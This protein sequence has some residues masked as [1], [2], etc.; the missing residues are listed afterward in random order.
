MA[1]QYTSIL[2]LA[3]PTQGELDG[4]WGGVVNDNITS[5]VEEAIAGLSTI[6]TWTTNSHTLTTANGVTSESRAAMLVLTDS[7]TA[8][9][10]AGEVIC[11]TAT[12]IYIVKNDTGQTITVKTSAG[13]G[14]DIPTG[15]IRIV[16][17]DGTNVVQASA[18]LSGLGVTATATELNVLDG[19]TATTAELNILDGVTADATE[20]NVLDGITATT[21]ELNILDG[22][23]STAAE[24]NILDG[25]TLTTTELNYVDGVTSAIQTQ[26]DAKVGSLTDLGVTATSAELNILDGATL[27]TTELNYVDGVT[28]AI[29]TQINAVNNLLDG[30]TSVNGID[31]NSGSIVGTGTEIAFKSFAGAPTS[32][33][34][35]TAELGLDLT[36]NAL[37]SSTDGTDVVEIGFN[38]QF[39]DGSVSAP[40]ITFSS[41]TD[42]G[43]YRIGTGNFA[44]SSNGVKIGE[45][46]AL[47]LV[48]GDKIRISSNTDSFQWG[49]SVGGTVA[50]FAVNFI[51]VGSIVTTASSTSYNTSSDYRLK[52]NV[53]P[54]EN[55]VAR[56]DSLNPVRFNFTSDPTR[57]V[58][59]FLAH[60]VTP[61]VP[62]AITGEKDA[63]DADGNPVYQGIDQAK[64][65]PLLVAAVQE[66]SARV[67]ELEAN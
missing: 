53:V 18:S 29:Q 33:D 63:V 28:S 37:Y 4:T 39:A 26:L 59:G 60:E 21:T 44:F 43:I 61:V 5:M 66:L 46:T 11:P 41:D 3:L 23:T 38:G 49:Y 12:K 42:T 13:T 32:G 16:F 57:T 50:S 45:I 55:A 7:G 27:T 31:I 14:V 54:I 25:A 64:L 56:I 52:E 20:I 17:C 58:D 10:G 24:L 51:A 22:V 2:K 1:T 34:L 8:L 19:I 47:G 35:A 62:E 67:A 6:N 48:V 36:N 65:V 40:S 9:T 15:T 30:T